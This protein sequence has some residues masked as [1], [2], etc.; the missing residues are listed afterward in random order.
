[1]PDISAGPT[2]A[3]RYRAVIVEEAAG[4]AVW[5]CSRVGDV[6]DDTLSA[7]TDAY[8]SKYAGSPYLQSSLGGGAVGATLRLGPRQSYREM[9]AGRDVPVGETIR[10][11]QSRASS[12]D[13]LIS[14]GD[15]N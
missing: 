12:S 2:T 15:R 3:P 9:H 13:I 1:M 10:T 8:R 6:L 11:S 14:S 4:R 7:V 5:W